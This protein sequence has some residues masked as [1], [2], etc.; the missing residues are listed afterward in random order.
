MCHLELW[1]SGRLGSISFM[2]GLG[3]LKGLF[4][5]KLFYVS[6]VWTENLLPMMAG[7]GETVESILGPL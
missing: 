5:I 2:V 6:I 7:L 3:G 1:F 4:K